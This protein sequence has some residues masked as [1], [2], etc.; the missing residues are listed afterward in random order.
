[1]PDITCP[2]CHSINASTRTFCWKC[3]ADLHAPVADPAAPP[4]PPKVVV[5][6]QPLLIGGGVALAA[7]ALIAILVVVLGGAPAATVSPSDLGPSAAATV[8]SIDGGPDAS[9]AS[10][11]PSSGGPA[12][13]TTAPAPPTPKPNAAA[14]ATPAVTPVPKPTILSFKG[15]KTVDCSDP[16]YTGFI[17][18]TWLVD[19]A[20]STEIAIDG[21]GIYKEYP[22]TQG[23]D[24]VPFG[25]GEGQ[26]AYTLTTVGGDGPAATKTLTI[27]EDSGV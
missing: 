23:S 13:P 20:D 5:P 11:D 12:A 14:P 18:L 6:I 2:V 25:C 1:M 26:H 17:T 21:T 15:P 27:V 24:L 10:A 3:A 16:S 9:G 4:P 8:G 7:I 19:F 22:G